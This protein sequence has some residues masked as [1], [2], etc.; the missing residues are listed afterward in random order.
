MDKF[1]FKNTST[2]KVVGD[3]SKGYTV[4]TNNIMNDLDRIGVNG[5]CILAKILQY[6][7]SPAHT[8]SLRGLQKQVPLSIN[9]I[10]KAMNN[11]IALGY[12]KRVPIMKGNLVS[13]YDY[14]VTTM[15]SLEFVAQENEKVAQPI[16]NDRSHKIC[17]TDRSHVFCDIE[18]YDDKKENKKIKNKEDE[19]DVVA[20]EI[21]CLYYEDYQLSKKK[22]PHIKKLINEFA[23]KIELG[24]WH[25]IFINASEDSVNNKY[26][27]VKVVIDDLVKDDIYTL[28]EYKKRADQNKSTNIPNNSIHQNK[29]KYAGKNKENYKKTKFH[30]FE[31]TFDKY[32]EDELNNIIEKSQA[33]KAAEWDKD[34][35]ERKYEDGLER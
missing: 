13:G 1:E 14:E 3:L 18:N 6:A 25:E 20:N 23:N 27:Y 31:E 35:K 30:N 17:D 19:E 10:S 21:L 2:I 4:I 12:V 28:N 26:K 24:L 8:I 15:P 7:N 11:L 33:V 16:E 22:L 34:F 9:T 32:S 5:F 29:E